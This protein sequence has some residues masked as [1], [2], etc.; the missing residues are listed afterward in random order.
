MSTEAPRTAQ[1][2]D[3]IVATFDEAARYGKSPKEVALLAT[4]AIQDLLLRAPKL[5]LV[6]RR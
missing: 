4:R 2:G 1:L 6:G 5:A 3:I